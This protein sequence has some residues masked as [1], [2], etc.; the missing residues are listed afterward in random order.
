MLKTKDRNHVARH[1]NAGD[2]VDFNLPVHSKNNI[3]IMVV[4]RLGSHQPVPPSCPGI[5][6]D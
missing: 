5:K 6:V 3:T 4:D 1:F 2:L